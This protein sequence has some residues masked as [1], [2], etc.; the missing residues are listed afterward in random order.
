MSFLRDRRDDFRMAAMMLTRIPVGSYALSPD[1]TLARAVW[2]FPL[3]GALVGVLAGLAFWACVVARLPVS[4]AAILALI[5]AALITGALHDDGLADF[6][7][8]LGGGRNRDHR[9]EIMRD[10]RIGT[11]GALAL[12]LASLLRVAAITSLASPHVVVLAWIAAGATSRGAAVLLL[13][14]LPP[15]R[16]DGLGVRA[17][18]PPR[19]SVCFAL[20]LTVV[21]SIAAAGRGAIAVLAA[22]LGVTGIVFGLARRYLQGHT[23]DVL[24]ACVLGGE[25]AVLVAASAWWG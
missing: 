3:V 9:L 7:D 12:V 21:I 11:Y 14:A 19:W 23:G 16:S 13:W 15:A 1:A 24:G 18:S 25:C 8:G 20:L 17:A 6:T 4:V 10:S 22:A 2:A 5:M